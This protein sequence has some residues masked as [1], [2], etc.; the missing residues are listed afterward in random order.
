MQT[1]LSTSELRAKEPS[2][3]VHPYKFLLWLMLIS[4]SMSF[5]A[6]TSGYIVRKGEGNWLE[7]ALPA[8]LYVNS[9]IIILSSITMQSAY[10]TARRDNI[11]LTQ[12]LLAITLLLGGVFLVGQ[13]QAWSEL[14]Q[15]NVFFAGS[16]SNPAGSFVYVLSGYHAFHIVCALVFV[17]TVLRMALQYKVHSKALLWVEL[18]TIFWHFLGALW[19]YLHLFLI[20]NR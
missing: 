4:T 13:S 1:F 2:F 14:V 16:Q 9:A 19:L 5:A 8:R 7:F 12:I 11:R 10:F 3:G 20:L 17:T 6:F 15:A 18:C